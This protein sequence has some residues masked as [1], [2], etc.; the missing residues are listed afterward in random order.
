MNILNYTLL[1]RKALYTFTERLLT[2]I[3]AT[4][5]ETIGAK[6]V[7]DSAMVSFN[8]FCL[9]LIRNEKSKHTEIL[10]QRDNDLDESFVGCRDYINVCTLSRLPGWK[11]AATTLVSKLRNYGWSLHNE[12]YKNQTS[13]LDSLITEFEYP[14][15][16]AHI[17]TINASVWY[18]EM[19]S[20]GQ[21]F[22]DAFLESL[23][24]T[25]TTKKLPTITETRQPLI[26][27]IRELL[28]AISILAKLSPSD[29]MDEL[30]EEIDLLIVKT[31][32][33]ARASNTRR[34]NSKETETN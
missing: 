21:K 28:T 24:D 20:D 26:I 10:S 27:N 30:L 34:R 4:N 15:N 3:K 13:Q 6:Q 22:K 23:I 19:K 2:I 5:P 31:M 14:E 12:G 18:T 25:A 32:T 16:Q 8:N 11:I 33:A 29:Q 7:F 1:S 9:A 17:D